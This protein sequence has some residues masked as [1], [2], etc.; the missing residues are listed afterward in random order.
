MENN[1]HATDDVEVQLKLKLFDKALVG[2][3]KAT[4]NVS[5]FW[6]RSIKYYPVSW[7]I[8]IYLRF[9]CAMLMYC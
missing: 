6:R 2:K 1:N 4:A 7:V 8:L 5:L 3:R 9:I